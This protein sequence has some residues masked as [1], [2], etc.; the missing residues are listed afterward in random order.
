VEQ[1]DPVSSFIHAGLLSPAGTLSGN[2][3][4]FIKK[5]MAARA[6]PCLKM[7]LGCLWSAMDVDVPVFGSCFGS[8]Y[9]S[10]MRTS[11]VPADAT[12]VRIVG[13]KELERG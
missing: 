2:G 6:K 1:R 3:F 8:R 4:P 11:V 13:I 12:V 5:I 7:S 10:A 9:V